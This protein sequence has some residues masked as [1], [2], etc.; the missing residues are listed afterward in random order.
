MKWN[1]YCQPRINIHKT[2]RKLYVVL[3]ALKCSSLLAYH[4]LQS[5]SQCS[6]KNISILTHS[7]KNPEYVLSHGV[8]KI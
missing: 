1:K 5:T 7:K 6:C 2:T 8:T 3:R 4:K